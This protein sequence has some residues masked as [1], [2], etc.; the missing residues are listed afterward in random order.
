M[1]DQPPESNEQRAGQP[2][3]G[4]GFDEPTGAPG[5]D[6][7]GADTATNAREEVDDGPVLGNGNT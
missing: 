4:Q 1:N 7:V 3:T 5:A 2:D 6:S